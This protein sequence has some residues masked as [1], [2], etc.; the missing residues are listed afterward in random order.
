MFSQCHLQYAKY[1][2]YI[3]LENMGEGTIDIRIAQQF[4][5]FLAFT[6]LSGALSINDQSEG[7]SFSRAIGIVFLLNEIEQI[8]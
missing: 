6:I 7:L 1:G 4:L 5:F 8:F 3:P 2:N